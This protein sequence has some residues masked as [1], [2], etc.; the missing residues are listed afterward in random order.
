[1]YRPWPAF[2]AAGGP[3]GCLRAR[4]P[5]RLYDQSRREKQQDRFKN[6]STQN[7]FQVFIGGGNGFDVEVFHQNIEHVG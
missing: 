2:N 3:P 4:L 6:G 1:M 5:R 7:G